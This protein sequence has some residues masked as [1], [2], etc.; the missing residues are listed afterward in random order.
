MGAL[1][2]EIREV[3]QEEEEDDED[4]NTATEV[5]SRFNE[6]EDVVESRHEFISNKRNY[7]S[8]GSQEQPNSH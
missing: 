7:M 8:N 5:R 1:E 3:V 6:E 2:R 4:E